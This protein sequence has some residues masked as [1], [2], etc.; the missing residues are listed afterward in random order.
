[1]AH[2]IT[3]EGAGNLAPAVHGVILAEGGASLG[4]A[5]GF[6]LVAEGGASL[7]PA[8]GFAL[9]AEGGASLSPAAPGQIS[10][11]A[12]TI[13]IGEVLLINGTFT[14]DGSMP[15]V[16]PPLLPMSEV[17]EGRPAWSTTGL[18]IDALA[19]GEHAV[20]YDG[21]N[22]TWFAVELD[23]VTLFGFAGGTTEMS[24]LDVGTWE[25]FGDETG[26][27]IFSLGSP[28]Q[29]AAEGGANLSPSAGHTLSAE[30]GASLSPSAPAQ[31]ASEGGASLAPAAPAQITAESIY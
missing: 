17:V 25:P 11:E 26:T 22:S 4:P 13:P 3:S 23:G 1:M 7:G 18:P 2:Q 28:K 5:A 20:Y 30:G 10:A 19:D 31:L 16:F 24:P 9:A 29:L 15:I 21:D 27:P 14:R 6:A 12:A 8:A